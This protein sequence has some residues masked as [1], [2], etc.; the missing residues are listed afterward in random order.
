[1]M[2]EIF[3]EIKDFGFL[4]H[5][6]D[7]FANNLISPAFLAF[8]KEDYPNEDEVSNWAARLSVAV[9]ISLGKASR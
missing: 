3:V 9:I 6:D 7:S 2:K 5:Q 1:M 4:F 8:F